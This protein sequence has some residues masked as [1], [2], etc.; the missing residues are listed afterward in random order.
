[1]FSLL[2]RKKTATTAYEEANQ[3][4]Y[5]FPVNTVDS[6]VSDVVLDNFFKVPYT[7]YENN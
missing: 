6:V 2:Y 7:G 1:M 3:Y 5:G 4:K